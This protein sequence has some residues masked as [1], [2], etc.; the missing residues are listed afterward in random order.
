MTWRVEFQDR[1]R[2][3]LRRLPPHDQQRILQFFRERSATDED[4][5]RI[6][7][8]LKGELAIYWRYRVGEYRLFCELEFPARVVRVYKIGNR[9]E[10]YSR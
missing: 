2:K 6:G 4:P 9:R 1:A 10:V 8:I 3:E 5:R 7:K